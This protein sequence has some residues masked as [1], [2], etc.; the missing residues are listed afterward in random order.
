[1]TNAAMNIQP[2]PSRA[3]HP[4]GVPERIGHRGAPREV[5]ENTL[6]S[7]ARTLERGANA[8]ELDVHRSSDGVPVVHH[9]AQ[10]GRTIDP[11]ARGRVLAE[12][13]AQEITQ[14]ELAPGITSPTLDEVLRLVA[15][16][17]TVYVELKGL[18][19]EAASIA[20][21]RETG[22]SCAL[23]SF[24]HLAVARAKR[25]APEIPRG[26]LFEEYP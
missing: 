21:I 24:D 16:R 13:T 10:I 1:M 7:F 26:I 23:H 12:M 5:V 22:A 25:L 4:A 20:A 15:G 14:V 8:I 19:V 9:D 17:A 2:M 3:S 18:G 11:S 6:P